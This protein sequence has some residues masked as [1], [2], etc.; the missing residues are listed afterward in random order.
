[1]YAPFE[2]GMALYK[3]KACQSKESLGWNAM[4]DLELLVLKVFIELIWFDLW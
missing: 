4:V 1:M 3:Q 2:I